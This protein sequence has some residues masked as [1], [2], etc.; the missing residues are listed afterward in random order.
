MPKE[1]AAVKAP[2]TVLKTLPQKGPK[3][4]SSGKTSKRD[5]TNAAKVCN[6][7]SPAETT[8]AQSPYERV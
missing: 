3:V 6:T 1:M 4:R 5:G 2:L 7:I 8:I